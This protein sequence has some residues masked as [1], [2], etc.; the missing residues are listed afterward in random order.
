MERKRAGGRASRK[1]ERSRVAPSPAVRPGLQGGRYTPMD[2]G[3]LQAIYSTA[4]DLLEQVGM[5][6]AIPEFVERGTAAGCTLIGEEDGKLDNTGGVIGRLLF[7]RDLVERTVN[8]IATKAFTLYGFDPAMDLDISDA[9][10]HFGTG[11]A[12]VHMLDVATRTF[13]ESTLLDLYDLARLAHNFEHIHFFLRPIVAR[14]MPTTRQ[15]DLNTSYAV[16][17]ATTKPVGAAFFMPDHV[18]Q[19]V[20]IADMMLGESGAYRKRPFLHAANTFVVPPMRFAS[21]SCLCLAEQVKQ[22]MPVMLVS[23][24]QAGATSPAALAG[25]LAQALAECLAGLTMVNL[26]APGHPTTVGMWPFVSDLRSGAMSGGSGEQALLTACSAQLI[27][28]MELPAAM[29]AGMTDAKTPDNQAGYEKGVTVALTAAAGANMVY[30]SGSMLASLLASSKEAFA[31]DNDML[32]M[33]NRTV[34][35]IEVNEGTL[36]FETIKSVV[37][38]AGHFLGDDQTLSL[39]QSEYLYPD[40]G[41]RSSPKEWDEKGKPDLIES[42][43]ERVRS[44]L[45]SY[46][47]DHVPLSVHEEIQ[48]RFPLHLPLSELSGESNRWD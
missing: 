2:E 27:N 7:P 43:T 41:D 13:E 38:G 32:G 28:W 42:A 25:S 8:E 47:P 18:G 33:I 12:A 45:S 37:N 1:A 46:Y 40:L 14:D 20:E 11:G 39:M 22:G 26:I 3:D 34:R 29:P 6:G 17:S 15:L 16:M 44:I 5:A 21:E 48:R 10:V 31:I 19:A 35:G 9:H 24:G 4:L 30:E 36:S 23:A